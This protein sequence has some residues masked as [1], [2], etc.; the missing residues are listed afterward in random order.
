MASDWL[1]D[2][3]LSSLQ[4]NGRS[5]VFGHLLTGNADKTRVELET[6]VGLESDI[7]LLLRLCIDDALV[8]VKLEAVVQNFLHLSSLPTELTT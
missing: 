6:K 2:Q 8:V 4:L 5:Q 1:F 7:D 3:A